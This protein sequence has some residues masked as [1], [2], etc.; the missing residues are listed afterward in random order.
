MIHSRALTRSLCL[1]F[2]WATAWKLPVAVGAQEPATA[3]RTESIS[4]SALLQEDSNDEHR[5]EREPTVIGGL[6]GFTILSTIQFEGQPEQ[7]HHF[8][9]N[10]S[11]PD[12][13]RWWMSVEAGGETYRRADYRHAGQV[14]GYAMG[15]GSSHELEAA[16]KAFI[17]RSMELRRALFLW[18][19]GFEW[20]PTEGKREAVAALSQPSDQASLGSLRVELD[21][22]GQP[23]IM[24]VLLPTGDEQEALQVTGWKKNYGR[25]WP[26]AIQLIAGGNKIWT[27][28]I[29]QVDPTRRYADIFFLPADRRPGYKPTS[30]DNADSEVRQ[31]ELPIFAARVFELPEGTRWDQTAQL[32]RE[33]WKRE[34]ELLSKTDRHLDP[35]VRFEI[36]AAGQPSFAILHLSDSSSPPQPWKLTEARLGLMLILDNPNQIIRSRINQ[37][38]AAI[39]AGTEPRPAYVRTVGDESSSRVQVVLPLVAK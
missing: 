2:C 9:A 13:T 4:N 20:Q 30:G 18:P 23:T 34:S 3:G 19:D 35:V 1:L 29:D 15:S 22:A 24:H 31:I 39:P 26:S 36:D 11:F 14:Y 38:L 28:V 32:G 10:Y 33:I 27:E 25:N 6:R 37:L 7:P 17:I 16:D 8:E 21:E 5:S 12:R